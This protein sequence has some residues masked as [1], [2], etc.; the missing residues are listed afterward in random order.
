MGGDYAESVAAIQSR[1]LSFRR[2]FCLQFT[3]TY[4]TISSPIEVA[5]QSPV[6]HLLQSDLWSSIGRDCAGETTIQSLGGTL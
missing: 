4:P 2:L 3:M 5:G 6:N 1:W